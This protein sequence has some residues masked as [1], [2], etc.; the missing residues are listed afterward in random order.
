MCEFL[1]GFEYFL[2]YGIRDE[3]DDCFV[4]EFIVCKLLLM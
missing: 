1:F 4:L 3:G 2:F